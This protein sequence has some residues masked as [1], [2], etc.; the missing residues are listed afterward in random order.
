MMCSVHH[1]H[2]VAL[3]HLGRSDDGAKVI[4]VRPEAELKRAL[5]KLPR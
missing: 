5:A 4:N 1:A 2:V 3:G